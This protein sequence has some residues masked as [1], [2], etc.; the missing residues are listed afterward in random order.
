MPITKVANNFLVKEA[1]PRLPRRLFTMP[2]MGAYHTGKAGIIGASKGALKV[3]TGVGKAGLKAGVAT[4][5]YVVKKPIKALTA[6][7]I[8]GTGAYTARENLTKNM[9]HAMPAY[10]MTHRTVT[11]IQYNKPSYKKRFRALNAEHMLY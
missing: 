4:G 3:T 9:M 10:N 1:I 6:A 7:A 2:A 8:L 11:G 5:K